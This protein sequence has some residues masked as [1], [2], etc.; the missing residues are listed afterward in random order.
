MD[1]FCRLLPP[2]PT[3]TLDMTGDEAELMRQHAVYWREWMARGH[4]IAFGLVGDRNRPFGMGV[5]RFDR[6][7]EARAFMGGDPAIR[8]GR[9]FDFEVHVMPAGVVVADSQPQ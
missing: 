2:R 6:E 1:F 4:V 9:G 7:E 5:V 3:F 8:S